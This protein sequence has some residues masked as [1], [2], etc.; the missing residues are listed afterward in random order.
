MSEA[1][2]TTTLI[3]VRLLDEGTPVMRPTR[4]VPLGGDTYRL[5]P[6]KDYDA[7]DET[8]QFLPG[9]VVTGAWETTSGGAS[10]LVANS[11]D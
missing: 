7:Q 10:V 8:W 4:G 6:T 2:Q 1:E 11:S 3:Y 9:T 5:L